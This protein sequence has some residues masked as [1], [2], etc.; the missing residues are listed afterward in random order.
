M[1]D[2]LPRGVRATHRGQITT[3]RPGAWTTNSTSFSAPGGYLASTSNGNIIRS[4]RA[5]LGGAPLAARHVAGQL[6]WTDDGLSFDATVE[7][8][9]SAFELGL[10]ESSRAPIA[11]V[12]NNTAAS[13]ENN[14]GNGTSSRASS[15]LERIFDPTNNES[16]V[17]A[18]PAAAEQREQGNN[19]TEDSAA[20]EAQAAR[21]E[22]GSPSQLY[23]VDFARITQ[24]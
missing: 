7:E 11:R 3:R 21:P 8:F 5:T 17:E 20:E 14:E 2:L 15:V 12:A 9:S 16:N 6:G 1:S 19:A 23:H 13:G 24:R 22:E 4:N 18:E 10:E